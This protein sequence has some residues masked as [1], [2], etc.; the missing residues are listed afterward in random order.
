MK[1]ELKENKMGREPVHGLL[2]K[3]ALPMMISMFVQSLYN[4]VDSIFVARIGEDALS[5]VSITFPIQMLM[6]S[7]A[8]GTGIGMSALLSRFLGAKDYKRVNSVAQNG[9]FLALMSYIFFFMV[10]FG[11]RSFMAFQIDDKNIIELGTTYLTI[12]TRFSIFIFIQIMLERFLQG[13][14][15]TLY[16][17]FTQASGAVTNIILD[18]ILIFGL[19]G[20]PKLGVAGAAYAT[21]IGQ[22]VSVII[23]F[24]INFHKN[25]DVNFTQ[26]GFRPNLAD[27][28]EI[29]KIG[30][31]SI[32]MQSVSSVMILFINIILA[33]FGSTAVATFGIYFKLQ[34]FIFMPV[35][36]LNNAIVPL[37]A[38]NYG[39][40]KP[41]RM[42]E[43][44]KIG[45][46]YGIGMMLAG[47]II[48]WAIPDI[49]LSLFDPS[50]QMIHIG[51]S[52]LRI[53]AINFPF[54]GYAITMGAVFQAL[55]KSIYSM[56]I[57]ISRQLL[58]IIP[59]TYLLSLAGDV[60]AIWWAF[61]ISEI[62]GFTMSVWFARKIKRDIIGP[63]DI[64]ADLNNL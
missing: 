37:I 18:P 8:I 12:V 36:G 27:I 1:E 31:P 48:F 2:I 64:K 16:I 13:T 38:Y 22:L 3:M 58:V 20:A 24:L 43:V 63:M 30:A 17:L 23:G 39:A 4:V 28:K 50:E 11:A 6:I 15:K 19:L 32:I 56:Y 52:M 54:A 21:V 60:T 40:Y 44:M 29:Y 25:K 26:R 57:S 42:K 41:Q 35:F 14:G 5:A 33:G 59:V 53:I 10:S 7:V 61:P 51:V 62:V 9:L 49:L 45:K 55:G 34:S 46:R 47:S